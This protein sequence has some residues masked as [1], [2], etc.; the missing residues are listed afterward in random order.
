MMLHCLFLLF[1]TMLGQSIGNTITPTTNAVHA[2]EGSTVMLSCNYTGSVNNLQWYRQYPRSK[3]EF[4]ILIMESANYIKEADPPH[5][6]L[7]VKLNK[8]TK[9]VDLE[10][11]S[12][13]VT[14]SALYY[15]ALE[16][17]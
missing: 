7:S 1:S 5:P 3:P 9:S 15:C 16:P 17:T 12:A 13:V 2:S 14:D 10:L 4:L 11:S 8:E 6:R